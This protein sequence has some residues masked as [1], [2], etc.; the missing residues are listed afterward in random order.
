M[1]AL[2]SALKGTPW[3]VYVLFFYLLF[4]GIKALKPH[5][6]SLKKIF[7]LPLIFAVWSIWQ[8]IAKYQSFFDIV[9]W[10][11]FIFI[12]YIAGWG[13]TQHLKIRADKKKLLIAVPGSYLTLILILVIFGTRYFFGYYY[14]THQE[15]GPMIHMA[16]LIAKGLITGMF[17][18]RAAAM[19]KKFA[20]AIHK[21]LKKN[22]NP[23]RKYHP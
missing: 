15:T 4:I 11:T 17:V 19:L 5:V 6:F 2:I 12:G 23:P 7:I 21:K 10:A 1:E 16:N 13:L 20:K 3:W 22:G 9:I 14:A 8:L 18:G